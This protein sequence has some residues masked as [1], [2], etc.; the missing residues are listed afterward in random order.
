M[1]L[2]IMF[3]S[4]IKKIKNYEYF[5]QN[6][7]F[8]FLILFTVP[9]SPYAGCAYSKEVLIPDWVLDFWHPLEKARFPKYF[10]TREK[11]KKEYLEMW[12][13]MYGRPEDE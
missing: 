11:R 7:K 13:K 12:N 8:Q 4:N 10:E 9:T 3:T 1:L 6:I 5:C 2:A